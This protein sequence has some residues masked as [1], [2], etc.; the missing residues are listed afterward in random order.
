MC[1]QFGMRPCFM[2]KSLPR[3]CLFL[4][5]PFSLY[6]PHQVKAEH[7]C[8]AEVSYKWKKGET[9]VTTPWGAVEALGTDEEG[10]K[11]ELGTVITQAKLR[12]L[13]ACR[14]AHE[15]LS[16]CIGTRYAKNATTLQSLPF[17]ARKSLE[18]S[19]T[20]D[21]KGQVGACLDTQLGEPVCTEVLRGAE[22][23]SGEKEGEKAGGK[24]DSK[25][26]EKGKGKK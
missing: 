15:N 2:S 5:L 9:E 20:T 25:K 8:R 24:G 22:G 3:A 18:D 21:C 1:Y 16:D 26:E 23:A 10:A 19:I 17:S 12:S 4:L 13:A 14:E 6:Y 11:R 7:R